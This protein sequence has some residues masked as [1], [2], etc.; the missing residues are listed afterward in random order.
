LPIAFVP[1][2]LTSYGGLELLRRYERR[3]ELPR[4]LQ[5]ACAG[6]G[7]DYGGARLVLPCYSWHCR[8]SALAGWST[9][10]PWW[11]IPS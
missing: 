8:T 2:R 10:G 1:Q 11:G 4:R 7:G 9:C 3:I 6:L 5:A